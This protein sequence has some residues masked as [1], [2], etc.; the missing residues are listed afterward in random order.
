MQGITNIGE[1]FGDRLQPQNLGCIGGIYVR[2]REER[3]HTDGS[4][5]AGKYV[6]SQEPMALPGVMFSS[7]VH[8]IMLPSISVAV[9]VPQHLDAGGFG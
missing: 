8:S 2:E 3:I 1:A 4:H 9:F 5:C 7:G 6:I